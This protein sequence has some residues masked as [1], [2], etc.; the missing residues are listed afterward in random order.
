MRNMAMEYPQLCEICV[1]YSGSQLLPDR[2]SNDEPYRYHMLCPLCLD[3]F[4]GAYPL[5][6]QT[7]RKREI[8]VRSKR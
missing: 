5:L 4:L 1:S 7:L 6:W 8:G 2:M 3:D